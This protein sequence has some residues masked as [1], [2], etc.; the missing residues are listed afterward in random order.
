MPRV[1]SLQKSHVI[2]KCFM[3]KYLKIGKETPLPKQETPK[4][5]SLPRLLTLR[6]QDPEINITL[7]VHYTGIKIEQKQF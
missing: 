4:V 7:C 3:R 5:T 6:V 1:I 2:H